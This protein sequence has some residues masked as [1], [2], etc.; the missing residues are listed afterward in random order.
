MS[1][2]LSPIELVGLTGTAL[3]IAT[4]LMRT[5]IRLRV[6]ALLSSLAFL[7]YGILIGSLTVVV[8]ECLL[9]PIN[10]F[11]LVQVR[12]LVGR[13]KEASESGLSFDWLKPYGH[14]V[15]FRSG[16][17][18]F[19]KGDKADCLYFILGGRFRLRESH[20]DLGEGELVGEMGLVSPENLRTQTLDALQD[21][22]LL[23]VDYSDVCELHFQSPAFGFYFLKLITSR[24]FSNC[25]AAEAKIAALQQELDALR[26]GKS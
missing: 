15:P 7:A 25:A 5:M 10:A 3:T 9:L 23:Q 20:L 2:E 1:W 16:D 26:G 4:Y 6:T 21:G 17:I 13:V 12:R 11:R 18:V 8:T 24:L 22:S 14:P 19:R